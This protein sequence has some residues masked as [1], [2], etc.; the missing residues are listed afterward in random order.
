MRLQLLDFGRVRSGDPPSD[1]EDRTERRRGP[2]RLAIDDQDR[3]LFQ[4]IHGPWM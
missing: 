3:E 1:L 2:R 4:T